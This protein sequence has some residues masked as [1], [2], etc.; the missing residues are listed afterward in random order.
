MVVRELGPLDGT[1]LDDLRAFFCPPE[2]GA[3]AVAGDE[4]DEAFDLELDAP[5]VFGLDAI[6]FLRP[7]PFSLDGGWARL[8]WSQQ[9]SLPDS[10]QRAHRFLMTSVLSDSGRTTPCSF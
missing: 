9:K 6:E 8:L 5:G 4:G 2:A 1:S 10:W 7:L 3:V